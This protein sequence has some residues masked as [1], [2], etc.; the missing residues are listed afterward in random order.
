MGTADHSTK[1]SLHE[2]SNLKLQT[3]DFKFIRYIRPVHYVH[4]VHYIFL[5][6]RAGMVE[7]SESFPPIVKRRSEGEKLQTNVFYDHSRP[8]KRHRCKKIRPL[9]YVKFLYYILPGTL[10]SDRL[11]AELPTLF[12]PFSPLKNTVLGFSSVCS[13]S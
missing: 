1:N 4:Q 6:C 11:K 2:I 3:S 13:V 8:T 5:N 9:A 7:R 10:F 12:L